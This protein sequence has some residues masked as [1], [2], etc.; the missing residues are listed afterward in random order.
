MKIR[1][2]LSVFLIIAWG[3]L[4]RYLMIM[5]PL[6][7]GEASVAQLNNSDSDYVYSAIAINYY[8]IMGLSSIFLIGMLILIWWKQ[9]SNGLKAAIKAG[10]SIAVMSVLLSQPSYAYYDTH[11]YPEFVEIGPNESAFMIPLSGANQTNQAQFGSV[12]YLQDKKV[13][14]KR[15]QIPHVAIR[16][17]GWT[18]D[19]FVPS[20]KLIIV[21]RSAYTK[22]WTPK[23]YGTNSTI[24]QS[25]HTDT[26]DGININLDIAIAASVHEEDAATFLYN[27]GVR[28]Q[29]IGSASYRDDAAKAAAAFESVSYGRSLG[30]VMDTVVHD[31]VQAEITLQ[32][33]A[34]KLTSIESEKVRAI[35][36]VEKNTIEFFAKKGI[37]IEFVGLASG[38]NYD[39]PEVQKAMDSVVIADLRAAEAQRLLPTIPYQQAAAAVGIQNAIGGSL[40]KWDGNIPN[41]PT[42]VTNEA[43]ANVLGMLKGFFAA[44]NPPSQ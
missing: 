13:A 39:N 8:P 37:T 44:T 11:D 41:M 23:G 35:K 26:A 34:I 28:S 1:I 10:M 43:A 15:V 4:N 20:A 21:D 29:Q 40:L 17:P 2:G 25:M 30:E 18:Y 5:A 42:V 27:F 12:S 33:G 31:S 19:Y 32:F 7:T 36:A 16:N 24:D 38:I 22:Q 3:F 6:V 9:I 14:T